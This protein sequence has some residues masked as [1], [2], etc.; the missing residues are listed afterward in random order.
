MKNY[1][2][3]QLEQLADVVISNIKNDPFTY[4]I[5]DIINDYSDDDIK[6]LE[7]I[8]INKMPNLVIRHSGIDTS[9]DLSNQLIRVK[10]ILLNNEHPYFIDFPNINQKVKKLT[11][12][13]M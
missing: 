6:I 10:N 8:L 9:D 5:G 1:K 7:S 13:N 4:R 12:D 2:K 11:K 3:Q